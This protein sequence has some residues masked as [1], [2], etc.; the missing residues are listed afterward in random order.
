MATRRAVKKVEPLRVRLDFGGGD[1]EEVT[2]DL[3]T[4]T[5]GELAEVR[6]ALAGLTVLDAAGHAVMEPTV[7]ERVLAHAWV[8]LRRERRVAWSEIFDR[9]PRGGM[10][11]V[12]AV[13]EDDSPEA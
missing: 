2:V 7:D 11:L 4:F 8:A 3:A 10:T 6:R 9:L 13:E 1:V 5:Y 12:D